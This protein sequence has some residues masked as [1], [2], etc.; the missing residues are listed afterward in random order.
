[1]DEIEQAA[2]HTCYRCGTCF[3]IQCMKDTN[4]KHEGHVVMLDDNYLAG[5]CGRCYQSFTQLWAIFLEAH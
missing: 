3:C 4:N 1:M 5:L 2:R